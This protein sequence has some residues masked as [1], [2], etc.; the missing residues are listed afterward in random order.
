MGSFGSPSLLFA[1]FAFFAPLRE[2]FC[3]QRRK[4]RKEN[5]EEGMESSFS[6]Q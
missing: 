4:E 3:A 5:Q 1:F 2:V 6:I